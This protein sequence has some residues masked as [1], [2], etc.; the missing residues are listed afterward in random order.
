MQSKVMLAQRTGPARSHLDRSHH[1]MS[2][3]SGRRLSPGRWAAAEL[4][5]KPKQVRRG[6][7][8]SHLPANDPMESNPGHARTPAG[9]RNAHVLAAVSAALGHASGDKITLSD[10]RFEGVRHIREGR[11][12][13]LVHTQELLPVDRLTAAGG[14]KQERGPT[15]AGPGRTLVGPPPPRADGQEPCSLLWTSHP[16]G[17][18][19]QASREMRALTDT[20]VARYPARG[21]PMLVSSSEEARSSSWRRAARDGLWRRERSDRAALNGH[22]WT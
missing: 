15:T 22:R 5:Q 8:F 7:R 13:C 21:Y 9:R 14:M 20:N 6:P 12:A 4:L 3:R 16:P 2:S 11:R 17:R 18:P 1:R 19:D 10:L